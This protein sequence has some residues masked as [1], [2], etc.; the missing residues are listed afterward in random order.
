MQLFTVMAR[1]QQ[2]STL[3]EL[4]QEV[5]DARARSVEGLRKKTQQKAEEESKRREAKTDQKQDDDLLHPRG[6][7][8]PNFII[9]CAAN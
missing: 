1:A 6:L 8:M 2:G 4:E 9:Y 7:G 5:A 3:E